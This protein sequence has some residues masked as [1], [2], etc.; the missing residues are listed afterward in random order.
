MWEIVHRPFPKDGG[1]CHNLENARAGN[2]AVDADGD[3][4]SAA[5]ESAAVVRVGENRSAVR[6]KNKTGEEKATHCHP[7]TETADS[8]VATPC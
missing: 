6:K 8:V 1:G 3:D 2:V 5:D 7:E 4:E